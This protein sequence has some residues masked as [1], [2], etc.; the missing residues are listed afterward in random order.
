MFV[1]LGFGQLLRQ[2]N[3]IFRF[4]L[5]PHIQHNTV[6]IGSRG[7]RALLGV[8]FGV[9]IEDLTASAQAVAGVDLGIGTCATGRADTAST[10]GSGT[11]ENIVNQVIAA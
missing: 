1:E 3:P 7:W 6:Q 10:G 11:L 2:R 5:K 8:D 4:F 9:V